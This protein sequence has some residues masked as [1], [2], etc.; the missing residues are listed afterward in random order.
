[1][2]DLGG[3]KLSERIEKK[4]KSTVVIEYYY[5]TSTF[6]YSVVLPSSRNGLSLYFCDL[7]GKT[8]PGVFDRR[9]LAALYT[10]A[11]QTVTHADKGIKTELRKTTNEITRPFIITRARRTAIVIYYLYLL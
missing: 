5:C 6:M 9:L 7:G 3:L 2:S 10:F 1:M 8:E 4:K 11:K